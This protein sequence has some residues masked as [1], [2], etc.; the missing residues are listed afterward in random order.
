MFLLCG[1]GG[2]Q[3][4]IAAL[5]G[6]G[7]SCVLFRI[8]IF[9]IVTMLGHRFHPLLPVSGTGT[10]FDSFPIKGEGVYG[11]VFWTY[12]PSPLI[13]LPSRERGNLVVVL[14]LLYALPLTSGLRIK[15]AM[16]WTMLMRRFH[17]HPNPLPSRERGILSVGL[18][19]S[20]AHPP[21]C[22]FPAYAGMTGALHCPSGLR[23]KSAMTGCRVQPNSSCGFPPTRE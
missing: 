9:R 17:P 10:G 21:P 1:C 23:I 15:S 4:G 8:R 22:G 3:C 7:V 18:A 11:W 14:A 2:L 19:C 16:T 20:P 6:L 5:H 12:S 13:P